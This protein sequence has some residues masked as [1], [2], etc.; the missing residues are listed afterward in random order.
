MAKSP[1]WGLGRNYKRSRSNHACAGNVNM[2]G[3]KTKRMSCGCCS[4]IDFREKIRY[5]KDYK[6]MKDYLKK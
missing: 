1:V 5:N 2:K 3:K 4:C 6:M